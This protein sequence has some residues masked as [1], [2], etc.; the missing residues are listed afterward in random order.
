M[1]AGGT[2][3]KE[4]PT[5]LNTASCTL[6]RG[7]FSLVSGFLTKGIG[8]SIVAE[9]VSLWEKGSGAS[10]K[11]CHLPDAALDFLHL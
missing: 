6:P 4:C 3:L 9:L 5:N 10:L 11:F 8:L 2:K 7:A 1:I